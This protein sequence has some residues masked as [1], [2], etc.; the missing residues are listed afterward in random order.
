VSLVDSNAET[1]AH[2]RRVQKL[3]HDVV[4]NLLERA[5][6]HDASKLCE[7]EASVFAEMTGKLKNSTYGSEEYKGFLAQMKPALDHHYAHNRHHPEHHRDGIKD[8]SLLDLIEMFCDWKAAT[9][10]HANGNLSKSIE[11]NKTRFAYSD[12]LAAIFH[13]TEA[14]LFPSFLNQ[15]R[16]YG[17]GAGGCTYNFCY[18]CGAG[19]KDYGNP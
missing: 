6:I 14:E 10:R 3:L 19:R 12:E 18:Q 17:C 11:L 1:I 9:E 13:R 5:R 7:P 4:A 15:W 2:I 8:M 16:C